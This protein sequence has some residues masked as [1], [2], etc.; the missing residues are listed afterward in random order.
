MRQ[1]V[2]IYTSFILRILNTLNIVSCRQ[3]YVI[4]LI[5]HAITKQSKD[6]QKPE[7]KEIHTLSP[8]FTCNWQSFGLS[9]G[10]GDLGLP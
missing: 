1:H 2:N 3:M 9:V 4:F 8:E 7:N 10:P 6:S 5:E